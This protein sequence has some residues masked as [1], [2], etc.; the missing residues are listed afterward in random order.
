MLSQGIEGGYR[1][2]TEVHGKLYS[3]HAVSSKFAQLNATTS[4]K[5]R[6][7]T[8]CQ[9]YPKKKRMQMLAQSQHHM[10]PSACIHHAAALHK[11]IPACMV[12]GLFS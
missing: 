12:F 5:I 2:F 6:S 3:L 10:R 1:D 4:E 8:Q 11:P 9:C 7:M